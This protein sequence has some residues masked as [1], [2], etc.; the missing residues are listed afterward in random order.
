MNEQTYKLLLHGFDTIHCAYYLEPLRH[1]GLDFDLLSQKQE[2]IKTSKKRLL[3][4]ITLGNAEFLLY[5]NG[6]KS[7]YPFII[8]NENFKI[9]FGESNQPNFF[10]TFPSQALWG[11]SAFILHEKFLSWA[12]SVGYVPYK[13][14]SL[15]RVDYCFDFNLPEIDFTENDFKSRSIKN[16]IFRDNKTIQT[17]NLGKGD[18]VLRIYDKVAEINQKSNKAWFFEL[19]K[20]EKNVW[21]I[22][23][24]TRKNILKRFDIQTFNDLE[25]KLGDLLRYLAEEHDT[26]RIPTNDSNQSRWP[27]HPLWTTLIEQIK[28]INC[29]GIYKTYGRPAALELQMTRITIAIL[30]YLKRAAAIQCIQNDI[31]LIDVNNA[32]NKMQPYFNKVYDPLT[33]QINVNQRKKEIELGQW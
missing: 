24:Q 29:L 19:W 15:S 7:G 28:D 20:Q 3:E 13:E 11:E 1:D 31:D 23:W 27:L 22:E 26:L 10:V 17:F 32:L 16:S 21:R 30:G 33:W 12:Q 4:P 14:E 9:E 5:P 8:S 25:M 2:M 18:I 6:S